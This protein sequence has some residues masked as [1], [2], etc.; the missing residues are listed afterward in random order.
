M[1]NENTKPDPTGGRTYISG[2]MTD[3]PDLNF[4][5]FHAAAARLRAQGVEVVNP[6]ELGEHEGWAWADYLRRDIKALADCQ[7][8]YLLPGWENSKGA[9]LEHHIAR[10]LGLRVVEDWEY[11]HASGVVTSA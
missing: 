8:I 2:P 3:M 11:R 10:E 6:A 9:R 1:E 5:A 4:P 7:T